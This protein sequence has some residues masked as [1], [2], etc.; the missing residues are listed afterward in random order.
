MSI[1]CY[2][3]HHYVLLF[4]TV[5]HEESTYM[6]RGY[7]LSHVLYDVWVYTLWAL[8]LDFKMS[9]PKMC[10]VQQAITWCTCQT[11]IT[12]PCTCTQAHLFA[13]YFYAHLGL[14]IIKMKSKRVD[15]LVSVAMRG[16][17]GN[18]K[19]QSSHTD[20]TDAYWP[21]DQAG[22]CCTSV[23]LFPSFNNPWNPSQ[24]FSHADR[25][26]PRQEQIFGLK[27]LEIVTTWLEKGPRRPLT[28]PPSLHTQTY[29]FVRIHPLSFPM[30]IGKTIPDSLS[31]N[32]HSCI[33]LQYTICTSNSI[34]SSRLQ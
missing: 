18:F 13:N 3:Y 9:I 16:D 29:K 30:R 20:W 33:C 22:V 31:N 15:T 23:L 32:R 2:Y 28:I 12:M 4:L 19:P 34:E 8:C 27:G 5:Q 7:I 11:G 10:L 21:V 24:T 25:P 6:Y 26:K 14:R 17:F 1:I